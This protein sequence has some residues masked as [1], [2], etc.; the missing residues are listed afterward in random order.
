MKMIGVI[1]AGSCNKEIYE[2]ARRV[3]AGI[4]KMGATLVCG[5]L[6]GVMEGACRGAQALKG[7]NRS[8]QGAASSSARRPGS[9]GPRA[10]RR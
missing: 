5:G 7:G 8:I 4:A 6:G 3:G 9:A 1:G 2:L 10:R